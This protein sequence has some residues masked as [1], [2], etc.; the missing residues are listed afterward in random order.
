MNTG[1]ILGSRSTV[2]VCLYLVDLGC[3]GV[4][5]TAY[6]FN[7]PFEEILEKIAGEGNCDYILIFHEEDEFYEEDEDDEA[8]DEIS[9][10]ASKIL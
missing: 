7:V 2:T 6:K 9:R 4:K 3:L 10:I 8:Q 1:K 5:D